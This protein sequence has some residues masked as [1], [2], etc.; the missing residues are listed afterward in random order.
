M[1]PISEFCIKKVILE[2]EWRFS[3]CVPVF[4][5]TEGTSPLGLLYYTS[6]TQSQLILAKTFVI[7]WKFSLAKVLMKK[8]IYIQ[9]LI[10]DFTSFYPNCHVF[11]SIFETLGNDIA[12]YSLNLHDTNFRR[13]R[14]RM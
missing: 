7:L 9:S 13:V 3:D 6:Q 12:E 1:L 2:C 10:T 4:G 14:N 8:S 11:C 5:F